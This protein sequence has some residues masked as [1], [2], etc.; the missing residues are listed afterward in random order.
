MGRR[1]DRH[2]YGLRFRMDKDT[3]IIEKIILGIIA[4]ILTFIIY[5]AFS[6][7]AALFKIGSK[8][9]PQGINPSAG[10]P[11]NILLL[12]MDIGDPNQV[13]NQSIKRTDTIMVVN[14]NPSTDQIKVVSVPRDTL[15]TNNGKNLK[16][17]AAYAVGGYPK[18]KTE[19][20]N[21]LGININYMVK[22]DYNAFV[23]L[24]DALGG[25]TM[26]IDQNMIY[27][28]DGQNLHINF[29]AG[30]TVKM[31]GQKAQEFFRW[32][33]NNDGTGF[34]NG[35]LDRIENQHKFLQKVVDKCKKPSILFKLPKIL[36]CIAENMS[37][38]MSSTNI[39]SYGMKFMTSKAIE[40]KTIQGTA[41]MI[42]GQSY[43]VFEK[44]KNKDLLQ[45]LED[46]SSTEASINKED[47]KILILN[48]TKING[49]AGRMKTAL[50]VLGWTRID[51]GNADPTE[52]TAIKTDNKEIKKLMQKDLPEATKTDS[53]PKDEEYS[54]YDVVIVIGTD[55]K[56]LGE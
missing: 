10:E 30:E 41:K 4:L 29:K 55:Y 19:V 52:K 43:L 53:K 48:G 56:K 6:G 14:Y 33:K 38:N 39:V 22:I 26:E 47:I 21:L 7:A 3:N 1:T 9:M 5:S 51:T 25:V 50:E 24:I 44:E 37:T 35:D 2:R 17:N 49:L 32:R 34:A 45:S 23:E 46:G 36:T 42:Q 11:V 15:I 8:T 12:G 16:I 54:S 20:E 28:D 31:D 13:D 40:M 27:D 18:I